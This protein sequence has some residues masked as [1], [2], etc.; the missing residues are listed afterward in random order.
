M[1]MYNWFQ[2]ISNVTDS[3]DVTNE[4]EKRVIYIY[5]ILDKLGDSHN[6]KNILFSSIQPIIYSSD[7]SKKEKN[8]INLEIFLSNISEILNIYKDTDKEAFKYFIG[9]DVSKN[10]FGESNNLF[11]LLENEYKHLFD[12]VDEAESGIE[13]KNLIPFFALK[14]MQEFLDRRYNVIIN[15]LMRIKRLIESNYL[16]EY[17]H[18]NEILV[19]QISQLDLDKEPEYRYVS[20]YD[21]PSIGYGWKKK[22]NGEWD[23]WKT[24]WDTS[25]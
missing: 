22:N 7:Y 2:K 3:I 4:D 9:L 19:Q 5:N 6:I 8:L 16:S 20:I 18:S 1:D 15:V 10:W 25:D 21:D 11:E 24:N 14:D 13:A 12:I 23:W 17:G